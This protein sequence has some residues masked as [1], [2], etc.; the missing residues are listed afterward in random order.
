MALTLTL[1]LTP[2]QVSPQFALSY[3]PQV[4]VPSY[5]VLS[6]LY[7]LAAQFILFTSYQGERQDIAGSNS[8]FLFN[9]QNPQERQCQEMISRLPFQPQYVAVN[10]YFYLSKRQTII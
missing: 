1:T 4:I 8:P 2:F 5:S 7:C 10:T 6:L 3:I 9:A